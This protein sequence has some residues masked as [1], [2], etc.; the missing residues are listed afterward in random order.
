MKIIHTAD[1]HLGKIIYS[2][3][4]TEDQKYILNN[5]I[6]YLKQNKPDVLIIA[7]DLYD[8]AVPPSEAVNLLNKTL[9]KIVL[10]MKIPTLI[11]SGNHDSSERLEFLNGI[12]SGMDL[13][14]EGT[15]K[16]EIKKVTF[17]D[18]FGPVNFYLLPYV[19]FQKARDIF[20]I[21]FENKTQ[22]LKH[23]IDNMNINEKERNILISHEYI[24]GGEESESERPLSIGGSEFVD[25]SV[26][27]K[28]DY[29]ALGHLHRPQKFKNEKINYS[30]SLLKYSFSESNNKKG[31][32][33]VKIKEK[34]NIDVQKISFETERDMRVM[35]GLFD[36][37]MKEESTD[38]YLQIILENEKPVYD[39]IN[40]LRSKFPNVL[41]LD[42]PNLKTNDD[43]KTSDKNIKDISPVE[44]FESFYEEVKQT[45][46]KKEEKEIVENIFNEILTKRS[47]K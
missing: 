43:I 9:S 24:M 1:W 20:E 22:A 40:K 25:Y 41:S 5:F 39:A 14:I 6:T 11:I 21:D 8:R 32:N 7:G 2:N 13:H 44:L 30:G 47:D 33:L 3:Y 45:Q 16:K 31:M 27:E 29:V 34:G 38:D 17:N 46:I 42:F 36:E 26:F 12:L 35:K 28:F 10:E 18:S 19:E 15:L 37:I 4:M 23:Y